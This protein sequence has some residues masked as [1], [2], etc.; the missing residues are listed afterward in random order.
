MGSELPTDGPFAR[1]KSSPKLN[2]TT[3]SPKS[4]QP[5]S[6]ALPSQTLGD[7]FFSE[8]RP[9]VATNK[10]NFSYPGIGQSP[11]CVKLDYESEPSTKLVTCIYLYS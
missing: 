3:A 6:E 8:G 2:A 10:L 5:R 1:F 7:Q 9:A 4:E 11:F